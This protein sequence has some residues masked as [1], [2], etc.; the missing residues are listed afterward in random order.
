MRNN[1]K[2]YAA[3]SRKEFEFGEKKVSSSKDNPGTDLQKCRDDD[4]MVQICDN[5]SLKSTQS[6]TI[7]EQ[8]N[9]EMSHE[10]EECVHYED[11]AVSNTKWNTVKFIVL[12]AFVIHH[13]RL[14]D[15]NSNISWISMEQH[16]C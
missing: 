3:L 7:E 2:I 9:V 15:R 13:I 12:A 14:N 10:F 8:K 5:Q 4:W 6:K 1:F 16:L 11:I